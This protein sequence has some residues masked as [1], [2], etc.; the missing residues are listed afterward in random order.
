MFLL[1]ILLSFPLA[2]YLVSSGKMDVKPLITHTFRI[3]E[4]VKAFETASD[5]TAGAI[6]V[7]IECFEQP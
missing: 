3:E 7:Q 5:P 4:A 6:K 1:T 2:I